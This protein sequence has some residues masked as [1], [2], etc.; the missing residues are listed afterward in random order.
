MDY[1]KLIARESDQRVFIADITKIKEIL[2]CII[3]D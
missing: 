2:E 3:D 1:V